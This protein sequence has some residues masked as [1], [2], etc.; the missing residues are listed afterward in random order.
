[1]SDLEDPPSTPSPGHS[2]RKKRERSNDSELLRELKAM[3]RDFKQENK[4]IKV[5]RFF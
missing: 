3:R 4:E 5:I 2:A 1:M